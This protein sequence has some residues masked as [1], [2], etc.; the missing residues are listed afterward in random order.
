MVEE[1]LFRGLIFGNL[2]P[3]SRA[4]AYLVS[5]LFFAAVH[6]WQYAGALGWRG[7]LL[8]AVQYLPA[9]L[10]LGW[11]YEKSATIWASVLVHA[12][13]NAVAMGLLHG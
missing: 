10:A 1:T 2:R 4:A 13:I 3:L 9:G 5:A 8:C 12:G 7:T 6:V 11:T